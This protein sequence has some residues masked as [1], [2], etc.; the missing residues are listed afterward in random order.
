MPSKHDS[1]AE[2]SKAVAQGAIPKGRG[3]EPHSCHFQVG[4]AFGSGVG[5]SKNH[6]CIPAIAQLA[7]HLTV[8]ICSNQMVPGSIPGGR[9]FGAKPIFAPRLGFCSVLSR[10]FKRF[11]FI[12]VVLWILTI[13]VYFRSFA[14]WC[15]L[16]H[17]RFRGFCLLVVLYRKR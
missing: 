16:A 12:F 3:F 11:Y 15:V 6:I 8:D 14:F 4:L 9:T 5:W 7:E 1:L 2:R 17:W 10:E 13:F